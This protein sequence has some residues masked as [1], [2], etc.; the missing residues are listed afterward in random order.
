MMNCTEEPLCKKAKVEPNLDNPIVK[1][2]IPSDPEDYVKQ[3]AV[4]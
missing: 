1:S 3:Q 4:L 2:E